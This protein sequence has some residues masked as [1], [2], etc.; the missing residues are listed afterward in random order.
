MTREIDNSILDNLKKLLEFYLKPLELVKTTSY[1]YRQSE[2]SANSSLI[3]NDTLIKLTDLHNDSLITELDEICNDNQQYFFCYDDILNPSLQP[4]NIRS[5]LT[6]LH[7]IIGENEIKKAFNNLIKTAFKHFPYGVAPYK[8]FKSDDVIKFRDN[9]D[10]QKVLWAK[11]IDVKDKSTNDITLQ[12]I[13]KPYTLLRLNLSNKFLFESNPEHLIRSL[14]EENIQLL[15][16][17]SDKSWDDQSSFWWKDEPEAEIENKNLTFNNPEDQIRACYF[18]II[19]EE[20]LSSDEHSL[21]KRFPNDI[22]ID[23]K[24]RLNLFLDIIGKKTLIEKLIDMD[25]KVQK[26]SND[27]LNTKPIFQSKDIV[28]CNEYD[29]SIFVVEFQDPVSHNVLIRNIKDSDDSLT[30]SQDELIRINPQYYARLKN[31]KK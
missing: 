29:S 10:P 25:K 20:Y 1:G 9:Y 7:E 14:D 17:N 15:E 28:R 5:Q 30:I 6:L 16:D 8:I 18:L 21:I 12:L 26:L 24:P 2:K 27:E 11:I 31:T 19:L 3:L 4:V 23:I 22:Y 13:Q